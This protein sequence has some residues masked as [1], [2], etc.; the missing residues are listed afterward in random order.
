MRVVFSQSWPDGTIQ[1]IPAV[2]CTDFFSEEMA[3]SSA[4]EEFFSK[5]FA[6]F[7]WLCPDTRNMTLNEVSFF[8][9]AIYNCDTANKM[10]ESP[11]AYGDAQCQSNA[12]LIEERV[13]SGEYL[14]LAQSIS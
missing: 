9:I 11:A 8:S 10:I 7:Q 5:Q 2:N 14:V 4:N 3:S 6:D 1:F 12:T 13:E